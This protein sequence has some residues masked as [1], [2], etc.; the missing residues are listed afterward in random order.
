MASRCAFVHHSPA[1]SPS[2]HRSRKTRIASSV[3]LP[4]LN[5]SPIRGIQFGMGSPGDWE[6]RRIA[7]PGRRNLRSRD[8]RRESRRRRVS[9]R[10]PSAGSP[11]SRLPQPLIGSGLGLFCF[12]LAGSLPSRN[13]VRSGITA[14]PAIYANNIGRNACTSRNTMTVWRNVSPQPTRSR[15]KPL[16]MPNMRRNAPRVTGKARRDGTDGGGNTGHI[17][18]QQ[19]HRRGQETRLHQKRADG[20]GESRSRPPACARAIMAT[21]RSVA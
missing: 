15:W 19:H 7:S 12:S 3:I 16:L 10:F 1:S 5:Q 11:R 6:D 8:R 21:R 18:D 2:P 20:E 9:P 4:A 14:A 17:E 13:R